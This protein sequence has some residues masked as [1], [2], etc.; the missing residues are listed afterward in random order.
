MIEL[1]RVQGLAEEPA[2][3][4]STLRIYL[5]VDVLPP[6]SAIPSAAILRK[7]AKRLEENLPETKDVPAAFKKHTK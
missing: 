5:S 4:I 3:R 7:E 2:T 1:V 6:C